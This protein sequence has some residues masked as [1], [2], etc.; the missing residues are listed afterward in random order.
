LKILLL[1]RSLERGGAERQVVELACGLQRRGHQVTVSFFYEGAMLAALR[2]HGIRLRPIAKRGRW[3]MARAA[4]SFARIL[5][6][7]RPQIIHSFLASANIAALMARFKL[8]RPPV[9]WSIRASKIEDRHY[10]CFARSIIWIETRLSGFCQ[11]IIA[12]SDAGRHD[13]LAK[14]FPEDRIAVIPNGIDLEYFQPDAEGRLRLQAHWQVK[15]EE[16]LVGLVGRID[17]MKDH[18]TF[19]RAAALLTAQRNDVRFVMVGEGDAALTA[20]LHR[21]AAELGLSQR[22]IWAGARDDMPSVYSAI[23]I[24]CSSS[25]FG[26]GCSNALLE[27]MACGRICVATEVGDARNIIGSIGQIVPPR[28]PAA[29]AEALSSTCRGAAN[30]HLAAR[31]RI[32]DNFSRERMIAA[33]ETVY[34]GILA[35]ELAG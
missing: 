2:E 3:D 5:D 35:G 13:A 20:S 22:V 29:L 16:I 7:E 9:V 15:P 33:T 25:A 19:L 4:L 10:S 17:P 26:E 30:F 32:V 11:G 28:D 12:N 14:G 34:S 23:D 24:L 27:A 1:V 21:L 31:Q 18:A 6:E 8:T